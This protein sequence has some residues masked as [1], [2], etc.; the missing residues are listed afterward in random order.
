MIAKEI[1]SVP[2]E[3]EMKHSYLDYAMSVIVSRALPD[4]RDGLKPVHRRILWAMYEEGVYPDR[5]HKKSAWIVGQ[6]MGR[7]HPHGESAIYDSLVRLAQDF[8]TRYPLV[9]G[10]G[11]FGS[12]DGDSPAAMRYTEVR[13]APIAMEMLADIDKDTVDWVPNYEG[14]LQEPVVLPSKIP[15]LLLNGSSGIAVGMA[16]SIPPHNLGEVIDALLLLIDKPRAG[17]GEIMEIIKGPDF[18]TGAIVF[19]S[20]NKLRE[21]Y[22]K[23]KGQ[24][25]VQAVTRIEEIGG[26]RSAIVITELPYQVNKAKLIEQIADLVKAKKL[27][28]IADL[29]DESD[30]EGMRVVIE[31]KRDAQPRKVLNYLLKHT[32]MRTT[33]PII[34]LA[35]VDGVP[36]LLGIADMLRHFLEHRRVVVTRRSRYE[37]ARAQARAHILE[38]FLKALGHIDRVIRIIRASASPSEARKAL[39]DFLKITEE[40][41]QAIL[42]MRLSQLTRLEREQLEEE[43]RQLQE[44]IKGLEAI[45]KDPSKLMEVIK[46]ELLE[47][48]QKYG[49][50]RRTRIFHEEPKEIAEEDIIP[51]E[52]VV[53]LLTQQGYIKRMSLDVLRPPRRGEEVNLVTLRERDTCSCLVPSTNHSM[54]YIFTDKGRSYGL[55]TYE[56]PLGSRGVTGSFLSSLVSFQE[57][58]KVVSALSLPYSQ[59]GFLFMAT[60]KGMVKRISLEELN[61]GKR[62]GTVMR[63][64]EDDELR[65]VLFTKGQEEVILATKKGMGIRFNEEE[66]RPMGKEAGGVKGIELEEGDEVISG[67][68]VQPRAFVVLAS[69]KGYVKKFSEEE[70]KAQRRGGKGL[71]LW[72]INNRTGEVAGLAVMGNK[73]R[74]ILFTSGGGAYRVNMKDVKEVKRTTQGVSLLTPSKGEEIRGITKMSSIKEGEEKEG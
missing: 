66:V 33:F 60:A 37:L 70:V 19:A 59:Q 3:E 34:M 56:V 4:V 12:I 7:Y 22:K 58:E 42:D 39:M 20:Q 61:G 1:V 74:F 18:P 57:G 25:S 72:N 32:A 11:N 15:Q 16:T 46:Q 2:V 13:L 38:G 71:I 30:R 26:G 44:R 45:L 43:M 69:T 6:V 14:S 67:D 5:A 9:D 36:R 40:Q 47:I 63:V 49:D 64:D 50:E 41:A 29:R 21:I 35:L 62:G 53:V 10:H 17:I 28:G 55:R 23:G 52:E 27:E 68:V 24:V 51:D 73:E 48:K 31:L 54:L 65:L 8:E